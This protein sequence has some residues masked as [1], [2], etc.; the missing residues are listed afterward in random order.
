MANP[1]KDPELLKKAAIAKEKGWKN[2]LNHFPKADKSRFVSQE[3][4]DEKNNATAEVFFKEGPGSLQSVFGSDK[5]Y[6]SEE[7]KKA[8]GSR[9]RF[10]WRRLVQKFPC[11]SLPY[12]STGK[13]KV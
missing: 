7:M 3:S 10:S 5:K 9:W 1:W 12:L 2:F 4:I 8:L 13:R 11:P 6:W